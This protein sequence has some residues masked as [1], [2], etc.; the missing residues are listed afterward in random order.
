MVMKVVAAIAI[1]LGSCLLLPAPALLENAKHIQTLDSSTYSAVVENSSLM[2]VTFWYDPTDAT[3]QK[4]SALV[5]EAADSTHKYG[6]RFAAVN[7]AADKDFAASKGAA[8]VPGLSICNSPPMKNPYTGATGRQILAVQGAEQITDAKQIKQLVSQQLL[9]N[10]HKVS[11]RPSAASFAE[12]L[13]QAKEDGASH[14]GLYFSK[15]TKPSPLIKSVAMGFADR[16]PVGEVLG[17]DLGSSDAT[18]AKQLGVS[19]LPAFVIIHADV[20]VV[21][22]AK[23]LAGASVLSTTPTFDAIEE[24][25]VDNVAVKAPPKKDAEASDDGV[26]GV[27]S[28]SS[29]SDFQSV[30][31]DSDDAWIVFA[32]STTEAYNREVEELASLAK[33]AHSQGK[34]NIAAIDCEAV[35]T[36]DTPVSLC[37]E[38]SS[39]A[40]A[41]SLF[42]SYSYGA[43]GGEKKRKDHS[44]LRKA[45]GAAT[46][47][48]PT[49]LVDK[50]DQMAL[51]QRLAL[52]FQSQSPKVPVVLFTN[53][54]KVPVMLENAASELQDNCMFMSVSN[55]SPEFLESMG[56]LKLPTLLI[57][58]PVADPNEPERV[59][60]Q[61]VPYDPAQFGKFSLTSIVA[62]A[63]ISLRQLGLE[64]KSSSESAKD[65]SAGTRSEKKPKE[66][67]FAQ[68]TADNFEA[69]CVDTGEICL[70]ALLSGGDD[71]EERLS[72]LEALHA[73]RTAGYSFSWAVGDCHPKFMEQFGIDVFALPTVVAISPK[74]DAF[75]KFIGKFSSEDLG[76]FAKLV[77]RGRG[78]IQK[79][80]ADGGLLPPD[81]SAS[82]CA[83]LLEEYFGD[84]T[85]NSDVDVEGSDSTD[86]ALQEFL[87]EAAAKREAEEAAA[88][89]AAAEREANRDPCDDPNLNEWGQ[90]ECHAKAERRRQLEAEKQRLVSVLAACCGQRFHCCFVNPT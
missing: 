3:S 61:A 7:A 90:K 18:L 23:E 45:F 29:E 43:I 30:V 79:L 57:L 42:V 53:K 80:Q 19:K 5:Q 71:N 36:I 82:A 26:S 37:S 46:R 63:K 72:Q 4:M 75:T 40:G 55:P 12:L 39:D 17:V 15:K 22:G 33:K 21:D 69:N 31:L 83:S 41:S 66:V 9:N 1:V 81:A 70:V 54:D 58:A 13:Q 44:S 85:D 68:L 27:V 32:A 88:A 84:D 76:R 16:L 25:L 67:P 24:F 14:A 10:V 20:E 2:W 60:L 62:W 77:M 34:T 52:E 50:V 86:E 56:A 89:A 87:R 11:N 51:Q 78:D 64:T 49:G 35:G 73:K 59:G 8:S 38:S 48:L 74:K 28:L 6:I 65:S 47:S